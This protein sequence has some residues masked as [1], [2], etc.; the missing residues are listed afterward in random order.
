MARRLDHRPEPEPVI[1]IAARV[2]A[3]D[4]PQPAV[5]AQALAADADAFDLVRRQRGE[6]DVDQR[7]RLGLERRAAGASTRS[8]QASAAANGTVS[9]M[10]SRE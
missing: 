3:L 7:S 6:I 1:I 9:P 10:P 8:A 5:I 4:D 2:G